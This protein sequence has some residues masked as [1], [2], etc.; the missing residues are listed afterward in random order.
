MLRFSL[1][2][3]R[4]LTGALLAGS[5]LIAS[6]CT[7][8]SEQRAAAPAVPGASAEMAVPSAEMATPGFDNLQAL[9]DRYVA[10]RKAANVIIGVARGRADPVWITS[11]TLALN[12]D[13]AADDRSIY[14][15]YSMTKPVMGVMAALLIEDGTL[16]LDQPI[17]DFFPEFKN[18]RVL[19]SRNGGLD[20]TV[21]A[22]REITIRHL[23]THTA[24]LGY[25]I[26]PSGVSQAYRKAGITP[27]TRR[28]VRPGD[29]PQPDGLEAF[30]KKVAEMPLVLQ[31]GTEWSYSI[32]LDLLGAVFEKATGK[33]LAALLDERIF[34]PLG[35]DDTGFVVPTSENGRLT[36]N[37]V[38]AGAMKLPMALPVPDGTIVPID[39]PP[40]SE[41]NEAAK[42][43]SGG[44]GLASTGADYITF[45]H[46][47]TNRGMVDGRQVLPRAAAELVTSNLLPDG[48]FY[49]GDDGYGAGGLVVL[50]PDSPEFAG[51]YGWGGAAGTLAS[52]LPSAN[53]SIVLMTQYLPQQAYPLRDEL[54][55]AFRA[56]MMAMQGTA[57]AAQ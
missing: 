38:V 55:A 15:I 42:V 35:M 21:P 52:S 3:N 18:M 13:V 12:S 53:A 6:A 30:A 34:T 51:S 24:G 46:M 25:S 2:S 1:S 5:F 45:M 11:G 19:R 33:P 37:Y 20:D 27:G 28:F 16:A 22:E 43:E 23:L 54:S 39:G 40:S 10:E 49:E 48:V 57:T 47:L 31:P 32:S 8:A 56:D 29:G 36:T 14:R 17:S 26:I 9:A 4:R 44:G 41:Y 7:T 50:T